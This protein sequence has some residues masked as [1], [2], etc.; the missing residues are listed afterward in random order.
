MILKSIQKVLRKSTTIILA[1]S[2]ISVVM[3]TGSCATVKVNTLPVRI[4]STS[5]GL[6]LTLGS[7]TFDKQI[8]YYT[9][10]GRHAV[11]IQ[12]V[13]EC[14]TLRIDDPVL[15]SWQA[16]KL[17]TRLH[18]LETLDLG[19]SQS[20]V[21]MLKRCLQTR[22]YQYQQI[23]HSFLNQPRMEW[24][25]QRRSYPTRS[26]RRDSL[27]TPL[28]RRRMTQNNSD[29]TPRSTGRTRETTRMMG[30][31]LNSLSTMNRVNGRDR[32]TS[33]TT[34]GS[35]KRVLDSEQE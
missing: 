6:K 20:Q 13:M 12:E 31:N 25:V 30:R 35:R 2:I 9:Y 7:P 24:N 29:L 18:Y 3:V 1:T 23:T 33:S 32:T 28:R 15:A 5:T 27:V 4:T 16:R 10:S 19:Y 34:G 21:E 22:L 17:L 8:G 26:R 14:V 11:Q